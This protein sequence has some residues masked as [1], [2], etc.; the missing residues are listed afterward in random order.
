M[1][2]AAAYRPYRIAKFRNREQSDVIAQ[3]LSTQVLDLTISSCT[4]SNRWLRDTQ[5]GVLCNCFSSATPM[6]FLHRN[7]RQVKRV[8]TPELLIFT[9]K[10]VTIDMTTGR[11]QPLTEYWRTDFMRTALF[12]VTA[13]R[14]VVIIYRRFGT[15]CRSHLQGSRIQKST[16]R[17]IITQHSAI[18]SSFTAEARN[19]A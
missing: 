15:T 8:S 11:N 2:R 4:V 16:T 1:C 19:D 12:C 10:S 18:L 9:A 7:N 14:V 17:C 6:Q 5:P 13:Q 3:A